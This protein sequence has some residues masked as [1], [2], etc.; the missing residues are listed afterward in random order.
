[1]TQFHEPAPYFRKGKKILLLKLK[2]NDY[3]RFVF[4]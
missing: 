4:G 3:I 1:M 2:N